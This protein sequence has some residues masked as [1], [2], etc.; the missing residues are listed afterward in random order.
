[1]SISRRM[2]ETRQGGATFCLM[3]QSVEAKF[4]VH[5]RERRVYRHAVGIGVAPQLQH[6]L[7]GG[8]SPAP[9]G[10]IQQDL[11]E[12]IA[13]R[14]VAAGI[15]VQSL[16][17]GQRDFLPYPPAE[18]RR[19]LCTAAHRFQQRLG[20]WT[21]CARQTIQV[22]QCQEWLYGVARAGLEMIGEILPAR[23]DID[24]GD[25]ESC[26]QRYGSD[27]VLRIILGDAPTMLII[28]F[29]SLAFASLA[30]VEQRQ[31]PP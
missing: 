8:E 25:L 10:G 24:A 6:L 20:L 5:R 14:M 9:E 17:A 30:Q 26:Q 3:R 29:E 7:R 2:P 31:V 12:Q 16:A 23:P 4:R 21:A 13:L 15:V 1:M 11:I 22:L 27:L 28:E 18:R 19:P